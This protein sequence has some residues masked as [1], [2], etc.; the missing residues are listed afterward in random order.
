MSFDPSDTDEFPNV[1][2]YSCPQI[3]VLTFVY[4]VYHQEVICG[5]PDILIVS[6]NLDSAYSF[7]K[8]ARSALTSALSEP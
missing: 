1:V 4:C 2:I 6:D 3:A 8:A 5:V 7:S